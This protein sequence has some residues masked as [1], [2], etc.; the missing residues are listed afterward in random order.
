MSQDKVDQT[1]AATIGDML[2]TISHL[3]NSS[4]VP[5]WGCTWYALGSARDDLARAAINAANNDYQ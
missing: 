2:A 4:E 3:M 1:V 5:N